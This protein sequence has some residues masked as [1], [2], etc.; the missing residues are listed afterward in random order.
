MIC[1]YFEAKRFSVSDKRELLLRLLNMAALYH[2][3]LRS[4]I[5]VPAPDYLRK[6]IREASDFEVAGLAD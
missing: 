4:A 5:S 1:N 3:L 2:A 6:E